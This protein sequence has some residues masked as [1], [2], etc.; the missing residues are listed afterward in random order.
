MTHSLPFVTTAVHF[1]ICRPINELESKYKR[2]FQNLNGGKEYVNVS[3]YGNQSIRGQNAD[4]TVCKHTDERYS[5]YFANRKQTGWRKREKT[6]CCRCVGQKV[7]LRFLM[8]PP[9]NLEKIAM[10]SWLFW[11]LSLIRLMVAQS[12]GHQLRLLQH[13]RLLH[14]LH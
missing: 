10:Q 5:Q 11:R 1:W 9:S 13:S 8:L 3:T 6:G 2:L 7:Q 12:Q 4:H 14:N